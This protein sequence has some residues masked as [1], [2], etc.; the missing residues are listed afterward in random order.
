MRLA[1]ARRGPSPTTAV[2]LTFV[3]GFTQTSNSWQPVV[4][5]LS[6]DYRCLCLDAPGH[7]DTP[8][9]ARTLDQCGTDIVESSPGGVIVGYSMG[10]RMALH[11]VLARPGHFSGL[12]LVS[13]TAGIDDEEERRAR[14]DADNA[15][16][17]HIEVVG[18]AAFIDE[19][20]A[21]P[22]FAGLPPAMAM[23]ADRLR[24]SAKGLADS[25]RWA[26]TGTQR[27]LWDRLGAIDV[28]VLII[29]G[30]LDDK[31]SRIADRMAR[32]IPAATLVSIAGAGHT[33]H[34]EQID[35]FVGVLRDWLARYE[36]AITSPTA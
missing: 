19:W 6:R 22:L 8:N 34:L 12:V 7:G 3:H 2:D 9:G 32:S 24:N 31:F 27:P 29:V 5:A 1:G 33:A 20:L 23:K 26:G 15:L 21:N 13:G 10:A 36:S 11:A 28:P 17:D 30:E 14:L 4:D 16:A 18:T 25:L 35:D